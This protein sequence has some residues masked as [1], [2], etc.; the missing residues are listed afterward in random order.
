MTTAALML[1]ALTALF[2]LNVPIAW[3]LGIVS[4]VTLLAFTDIPLLV[5]PQRMFTGTDS[6]TLIAIPFFLL[7]GAL[8]ER[9]GISDKLI[10]LAQGVVGHIRG[11]LGGISVGSS[12]LF[13]SVSGSG[14]ATTSA[15]GRITIPAMMER[16]YHASYAT[17][18]QAS[19]GAMGVIIPPSIVMILYSVITGASV[20]DLFL[21]G[22]LPGVL[23]GGLLMVAGY[24]VAR[25]RGYSTEARMPVGSLV[26]TL[27]T[28]VPAL[29]MPVIILGGILLGI[30]T[31]TEAAVL[32]VVYAFVVGILSRRLRLNDLPDVLF[33]VALTSSMIML[34]VANASA[35]AW[36]VTSQ[37]LPQQLSSF[38]G[39]VSTN[40]LFIIA[41]C[42]LL[43]LVAGMFLDTTA[44]LIILIPVM[45]PIVNVV[46]IDPVHFGV[47]AVVALAI[48]LATP[49]VGLNLFVAAGI[50]KIDILQAAS[51]LIP[52]LI[53]M[54]VALILLILFPQL[55]TWL[56]AVLN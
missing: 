11:G 14:V 24:L 35:F 37:Q 34:L 12:M 13:S 27:I 10:A 4:L 39:S 17:C 31:P 53:S 42:V 20:A 51:G 8:M 56:P 15:I 48:G 44:A 23:I 38:L 36:V 5:V 18:I 43:L 26:R 50:A 49:P 30:V 40:P 32:A 52:F 7:A 2:I 55:S 45:F 54:L 41:V 3:A 21:G 33:D 16:G 47:V 6:F 28:S 1:A 22:I 29:L 46:G 19:A 25:R 9:S